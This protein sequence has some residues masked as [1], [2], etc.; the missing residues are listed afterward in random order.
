MSW[1]PLP[2]GSGASEIVAKLKAIDLDVW[3]HLYAASAAAGS[4]AVTGKI[5]SF[6]GAVEVMRD[7]DHTTST[8]TMQTSAVQTY[9]TVLTKT[10]SSLDSAKTY[11]LHAWANV[12]VEPHNSATNLSFASRWTHDGTDL[13]SNL[14]TAPSAT[15]WTAI[16]GNMVHEFTGKTSYV[17]EYKIYSYDATYVGDI[18][19]RTMSWQLKEIPQ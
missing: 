7:E 3:G 17:L 18:M 9:T 6:G 15:G 14:V 10:F 5:T 4:L 2:E 19:W 12:S 1:E 11:R 13:S 16:G 8:A